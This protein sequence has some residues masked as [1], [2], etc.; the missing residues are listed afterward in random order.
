MVVA[1][2]AWLVA[3]VVTLCTLDWL[4]SCHRSGQEIVRQLDEVL[5]ELRRNS[6]GKP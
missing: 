6:A 3:V 2:V 1:Y 5:E 4:W